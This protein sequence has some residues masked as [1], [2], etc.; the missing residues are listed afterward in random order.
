MQLKI[1]QL[2]CG[3]AAPALTTLVVHSTGEK[4]K[5]ALSFVLLLFLLTLSFEGSCLLAAKVYSSPNT[6]FLSLSES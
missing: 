5:Q 3:V 1:K 6:G 4:K 2:H